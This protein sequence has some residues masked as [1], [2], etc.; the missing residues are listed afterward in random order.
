MT[1]RRHP[2]SRLGDTVILA[3]RMGSQKGGS[4]VPPAFEDGGTTPREW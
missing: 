3:E 1:P 4:G 2:A